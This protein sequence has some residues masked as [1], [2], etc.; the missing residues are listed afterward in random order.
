VAKL[1]Y[2]MQIIYRR[3]VANDRLTLTQHCNAEFA[4][5]SRSQLLRLRDDCYS[6][7]NQI[8]E[9]ICYQDAHEDRT[10]EEA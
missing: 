9:Y 7:A 10:V 5:M 8:T 4:T 2:F 1:Y 3:V 6:F